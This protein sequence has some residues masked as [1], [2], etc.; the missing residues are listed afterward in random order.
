MTETLFSP[1]FYTFRLDFNGGSKILT[2]F[3]DGNPVKI[4]KK[5]PKYTQQSDF[6]GNANT[7]ESM[8]D[9]A[10]LTIQTI[11]GNETDKILY[12]LYNKQQN[13][14]PNNENR[15]NFTLENNATHVV[16]RCYNCRISQVPEAGANKAQQAPTWNILVGKSVTDSAPTGDPMF[17]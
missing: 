9:T 15:F 11:E 6:M 16:T 1:R 14:S 3:A 4:T 10:T 17:D 13:S 8:D 12:A 2:E 7:F 5:T